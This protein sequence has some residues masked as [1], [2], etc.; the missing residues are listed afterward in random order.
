MP[1]EPGVRHIVYRR[2][3]K[4]CLAPIGCANL[5]YHVEKQRRGWFGEYRSALAKRASTSSRERRYAA[6][7]PSRQRPAQ[8]SRRNTQAERYSEPDIRRTARARRYSEPDIRR[9]EQARRHSASEVR[10]N[11]RAR[12]RADAEIRRNRIIFV[13]I[14]LAII[15]AIV[16]MIRSCA[17]D[18]AEDVVAPDSEATQTDEATDSESTAEE[19]APAP[20]STQGREA[21]IS[22]IISALSE[23]AS[24][25]IDPALA[26]RTVDFAVDPN[27]TDWN[28]ESNG[29][30]V[31]YLTIDDGPSDK[32]QQILDILDRYGCK[33]TFFV[34][35]RDVD[36]FP[37]IKKAFDKGHTIGLHSYSHDYAYVYSSEAAYYDDLDSI[38]QMVEEQIGFVPAFI[39]FPGGSS[40]SVSTEYSAGIM[41]RLTESVQGR[42]YQYYDWN[43][44]SG[45]GADISTE[46]FVENCTTGATEYENIVM[47]MHDSAAKQSSVDGLPAVIEYWQAKGY[48]FEAIDRDSF[49]SHHGVSN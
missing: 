19:E 40:N 47:L 45:D 28:Y 13:L 12:R 35:G 6:D 11:A 21:F 43:V 25:A 9:A 29:R 22:L 3:K 10:R 41:T 46:D 20:G 36:H 39:R 32:T 24:V 5:G 34:I 7:R 37:I 33:A 1:A 49:V 2:G 42:G 17:S 18:V 48:T 27:R 14:I 44:S 30:K 26:Q 38:G 15:V 23:T 4:M 31:I 16:F 8:R